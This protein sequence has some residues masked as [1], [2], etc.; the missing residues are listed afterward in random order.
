VVVTVAL[1]AGVVVWAH[2]RY[3]SIGVAVAAIRGE[4]LAISPD[5]LNLGT[6]PVGGTVERTLQVHNLSD[7]PV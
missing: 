6:V 4:S 1:L 7:E 2:A 5:R 3:G